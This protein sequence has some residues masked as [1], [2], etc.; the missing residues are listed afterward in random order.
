MAC[1]TYVESLGRRGVHFFTTAAIRSSTIRSRVGKTGGR[2]WRRRHRPV[3]QLTD[4]KL[5]RALAPGATDRKP[6]VTLSGQVLE[7]AYE[8]EHEIARRS[9]RLPPPERIELSM[10]VMYPWSREGQHS[11]PWEPAHMFLVTNQVIVLKASGFRD[12]DLNFDRLVDL[13]FGS[14]FT[15]IEDPEDMADAM[16]CDQPSISDMLIGHASDGVCAEV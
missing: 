2:T 13:D 9:I 15:V 11:V 4:D 1:A 7:K 5:F 8:A 10:M 6:V 12:M 16:L 14:T 3:S